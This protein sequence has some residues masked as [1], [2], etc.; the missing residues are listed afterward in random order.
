M[1]QSSTSAE[2]QC[3]GEIDGLTAPVRTGNNRQTTTDIAPTINVNCHARGS[4]MC[5]ALSGG[6]THL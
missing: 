3:S 6:P 2:R 1:V 5:G 4:H